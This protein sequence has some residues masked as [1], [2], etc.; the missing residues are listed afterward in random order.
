MTA[1]TQKILFRKIRILRGFADGKMAVALCSHC[2]NSTVFEAEMLRAGAVIRCPKCS[3]AAIIAD[4][5]RG[6]R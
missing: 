4:C 3:T 1:A 5:R 6:S 2:Q